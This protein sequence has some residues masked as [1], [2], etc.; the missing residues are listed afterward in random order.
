M[1][2]LDDILK[3]RPTPLKPGQGSL[4]ISEPFLQDYFFR[5]SVVLLA[6]HNDEGSFGVII[7]KPVEYAFNEVVSGFPQADLPIF[8]GGPVQTDRLFYI[9]TLGSSEIEG[10]LE[11]MK[12]LWWG[13]DINTVRLLLSSG[14][15]NTQ[16]IRFF[17]G[18]SGWEPAQLD[19][20]LEDESWIIV[21]KSSRLIM[22]VDPQKMW[23]N[24]VGSLGDQ[25][26]LW[27]RFPVDPALN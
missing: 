9:H 11:V 21:R 13:G 2:E 26:T 16:N 10:S 12:G 23:N 20:E 18:Y 3:H 1:S 7:N 5:R 25:Y 27:T 24:I 19:R 15:L 22:S 4:L 8:L 14:R 17:V 6:E